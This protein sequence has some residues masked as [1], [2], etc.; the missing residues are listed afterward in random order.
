VPTLFG[1]AFHTCQTALIWTLVVLD[2]HPLIARDLYDELRER[3]AGATPSVDRI[4]DLPLLDAVVKEGM[5]ILPPV[6]LQYR[7]AVR[8]TTLLGHP[9]RAERNRV[10]L[11][12]FLTNRQ[13]D[14][15]PEPDRFRPERW[16]GADPLPYE[17]ASFSDGPR[18]CPG[19]WFGVVAI[20]IAVATIVARYRP[21]IVAGTRVDHKLRVTL[22]PRKAVPA[23]LHRQDGAFTAAPLRGSIRNLLQLPH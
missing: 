17:F 11:S 3:L 2:Q 20:K 18:K 4:A 21:A 22:S 23:V 6:P 15:Y 7:V 5:R 12:S 19:Q 14:L 16:F 1:A 10:L 8:D 13:P 9:V